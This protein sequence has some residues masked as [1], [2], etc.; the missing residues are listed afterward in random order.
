MAATNTSAGTAANT[1]NITT[2]AI[3]PPLRAAV[4][5]AKMLVADIPSEKFAMMPFPTMNHPAFCLGHLSLYPDRTLELV[6]QADLVEHR[7]EYAEL[8]A[9]GVECFDDASRYPGKDEIVAYYVERHGVVADILGGVG[10]E[11]YE[12]ENPAGGGFKEML[13]TIGAVVNFMMNS[14]Q[15]AHLGQ[16]S[17]WRR[18]IGLP[19]VM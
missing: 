19:S 14:H 3:L 6:G 11:I 17:A 5:Y 16:I 4:G 2:A 1:I 8:F 9:E 7:A 12:R 13:P 18:V 10:D 15:M